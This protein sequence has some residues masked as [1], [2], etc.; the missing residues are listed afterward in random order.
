EVVIG[1]DMQEKFAKLEEDQIRFNKRVRE[2]EKEVNREYKSKLA[3]YKFG[4]AMFMPLLVIFV[5]ICFAFARRLK[6]AAR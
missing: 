2:L 6:I 5:G 3:S 4:N 1:A